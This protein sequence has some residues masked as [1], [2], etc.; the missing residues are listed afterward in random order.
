MKIKV[1]SE[2]VDNWKSYSK[3]A[4]DFRQRYFLI[5]FCRER[6]FKAGFKNQIR[7]LTF[8]LCHLM[9]NMRWR[10]S[11]VRYTVL[12]F[13]SFRSCFSGSNLCDF[14]LWLKLNKEQ[15]HQFLTIQSLKILSLLF[16]F[17]GVSTRLTWVNC[18]LKVES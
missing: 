6:A 2:L 4:G 14:L 10:L 13:L 5:F 9:K 1:R 16:R 3:E 8:L 15:K 18:D 12:L 11:D 17:I 7:A